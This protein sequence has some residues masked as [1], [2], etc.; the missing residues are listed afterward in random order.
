MRLLFGMPKECLLAVE[1][2][3]ELL[4]HGQ[5]LPLELLDFFCC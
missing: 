4:F 1:E 2:L 3:R 5:E